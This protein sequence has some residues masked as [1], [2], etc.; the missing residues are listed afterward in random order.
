MKQGLMP[1]KITQFLFEDEHRGICV[2][3]LAF[4][5]QF[6][7][8]AATFTHSGRVNTDPAKSAVKMA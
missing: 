1:W 5:V 3:S 7:Q 6:W 2:L 4:R 8:G